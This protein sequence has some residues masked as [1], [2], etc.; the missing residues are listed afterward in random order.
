M[1]IVRS[2]PSSPYSIDENPAP[3]PSSCSSTHTATATAAPANTALHRNA[4]CRRSQIVSLA[5]EGLMIEA[6]QLTTGGNRLR[7]STRAS[8]TRRARTHVQY[9]IAAGE[10]L[11]AELI[12]QRLEPLCDAEVLAHRRGQTD[13]TGRDAADVGECEL[14]VLAKVIES[15]ALSQR[16]H[17]AAMHE[18]AAPL[19]GG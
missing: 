13:D 9:V 3:M 16:H 7:A 19:T 11:H 10:R 15:T 1:P 2:L 5:N 17:R 6:T 14:D 8:R 12:G 18:H 4:G